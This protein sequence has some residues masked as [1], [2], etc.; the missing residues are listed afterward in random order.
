MPPATID[1]CPLMR[2]LPAVVS[3]VAFAVAGNDKHL[4]LC[5]QHLGGDVVDCVRLLREHANGDGC[6]C[7]GQFDF[8]KHLNSFRIEL[9]LIGSVET[10]LGDGTAQ[11]PILGVVHGRG[12]LV[13]P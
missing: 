12:R 6:G 2:T 5:R 11:R 1:K 13:A 7:G 10:R 4:G 9:S 8:A 3:C